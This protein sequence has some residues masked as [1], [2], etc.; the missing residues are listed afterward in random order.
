[1]NTKEATEY[2]EARFEADFHMTMLE[3]AARSPIGFTA[4]V[5]S[6]LRVWAFSVGTDFVTAQKAA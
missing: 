2:L 3:F 1:M 4:A 5:R 6:A